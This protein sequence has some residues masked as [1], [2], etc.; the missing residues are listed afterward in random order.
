MNRIAKPAHQRSVLSGV[1]QGL[2]LGLTMAVTPVIAQVSDSLLDRVDIQPVSDESVLQ[3]LNMHFYQRC[4]FA[5]S[6]PVAAA[7]AG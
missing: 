1:I 7:N 2:I 4:N 6:S 3:Q 5:A